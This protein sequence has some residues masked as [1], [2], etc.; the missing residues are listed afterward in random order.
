MRWPPIQDRLPDIAILPPVAT[1]TGKFFSNFSL[2]LFVDYTMT[3]A[4]FL[5]YIFDRFRASIRNSLFFIDL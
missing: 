3:N 4:F 2:C 5:V 1:Y